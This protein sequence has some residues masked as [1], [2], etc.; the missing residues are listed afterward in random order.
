MMFSSSSLL[1]VK[2]EAD[3][4]NIGCVSGWSQRFIT[5]RS[6]CHAETFHWAC[7]QSLLEHDLYSD[8]CYTYCKQWRDLAERLPLAKSLDS[9]L[10]HSSDPSCSICRSPDLQQGW[11]QQVWWWNHYYRRHM[12]LWKHPQLPRWSDWR[13]S[14]HWSRLIASS[15]CFWPPVNLKSLQSTNN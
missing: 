6:V 12:S 13:H 14:P 11:N 4:P 2:A 15:R 8:F 3:V 9:E 5:I 10:C 7:N 1:K